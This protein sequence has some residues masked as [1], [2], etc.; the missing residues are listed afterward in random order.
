MRLTRRELLLGTA[1]LPL[2]SAERTPPHPSVLLIVVD[3][4][5][6]HMLGCYGNRE[7]RTPNIDILSRSGAR[8]ARAFVATPEPAPSRATLLSGR[9]PHQ[10][11]IQADGPIVLGNEALLSDALAAAGYDCGYC[12]TWDF[13]DSSEHGIKF[14]EKSPDAG[15]VSA[16]A[17]EFLDSRQHGQPFF[18]TASYQLPAVVAQKYTDLYRGVS[19]D[20]VG[21]EPAASNATATKAIL[22]DLVGAIRGAAASVTAL[23]DEVQRLVKKLDE[24]GLRDDTVIVFTATCGSMLGRHGLWGDGFASNPPNMFEEVVRVPAIWQWGRR[25]PPGSL[26]PE[27]VRSFDLF[28]T[29][30]E[31]TGATPPGA[32]ANLPGRSYLSAVVNSPFPKKLPWAN[33]GFGEL[34]KARMVRDKTY[35]LVL[36]EGGPNELYDVEHDAGEKV[37]QYAGT[38]FLNVRDGLTQTLDGWSKQF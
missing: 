30:C 31:L 7:I 2:F 21:W 27:L 20:S 25:I 3:G 34:G 9:T 5:G 36:R 32:A 38:Q 33:L 24:R 19:F 16:K 28:Q 35:K 22:K 29:I 18:L 12:G 23:D 26:R 10:L 13:G 1:A 4:L 37:N 14:W 11:G 8:F 6:A 15:A 17:L